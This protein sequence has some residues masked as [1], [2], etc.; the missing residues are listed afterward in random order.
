M[1]NS[2]V[3]K[4]LQSLLQESNEEIQMIEA[5][6]E[7]HSVPIMD[8]I[9]IQFILQLIMIQK[10]KNI[11]EIGTAIG[12]SAIKMAQ[13]APQANIVTIDRDEE[14]LALAKKHIEHF[15]LQDRIRII[16][17]DGQAMETVEKAKEYGPY[18]LLF[19]DASKGKYELFYQQYEPL[20]SPNGVII[21]DNVL[22]KGIVTG[23]KEA[24]TRRVKQMVEKLRRYNE[25]RMRDPRFETMIYPIGDGIMVSYKK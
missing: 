16:N 7:E 24:P 20:L 21:S 5:Y 18:D 23:E 22:F 17:G 9:S 19:I 12:Y 2:Q 6:A 11:L 4:Y 10:P 8:K 3:E 15:S 25:E 14:R 13:A 1:A